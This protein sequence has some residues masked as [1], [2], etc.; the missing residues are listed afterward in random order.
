MT[1]WVNPPSGDE[2]TFTGFYDSHGIIE[3]A[4]LYCAYRSLKSD[5]APKTVLRYAQALLLYI[6]YLDQ[7]DFQ[8]LPYNS[9]DYRVLNATRS[10]IDSFL[11]SRADAGIVRST[12]RVDETAIRDFYI[13]LTTEEGGRRL[14]EHPYS[15]KTKFTTL[16]P[17]KNLRFGLITDQFIRLLTGLHNECERAFWQ[18]AHDIG[19]RIS[20]LCMLTKGSIDDAAKYVQDMEKSN[21]APRYVP[22]MIPLTKKGGCEIIDHHCLIAVPTLERV[23]EYH[24]TEAYEG[25]PYWDYDDQAKPA[26]LSVNGKKWSTGNAERSIREAAL[27]KGVIMPKGLLPTPHTLRHSSAY[28]ILTSAD[29][30]AEAVE[31][32]VAAMSQLGHSSLR[33]TQIYTRLPLPLQNSEEQTVYDRARRIYRETY[34][35]PRLHKERRGHKC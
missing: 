3:T 2:I 10:H 21:L 34:L 19:A 12:R 5:Y 11:K 6:E 15:R 23:L 27:R 35:P 20:T 9:S 18:F 14:V 1:I 24:K 30:G 16:K 26:F 28:S 17:H 4:T 7:V 32:L 22:I 31:R 13:W 33:A 25:S 29:H 8:S